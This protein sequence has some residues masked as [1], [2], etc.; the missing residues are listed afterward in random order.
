M[1]T[2][3]EDIS[4]T[5]EICLRNASEFQALRLNVIRSK[6]F[7]DLTRVIFNQETSIELTVLKILANLIILADCQFAQLVLVNKDTSLDFDRV[8]D[9]HADDQVGG[10]FDHLSSP[11]ENRFIVNSGIISI[12]AT[13]GEKV[14]IEDVSEASKENSFLCIPPRDNDNNTIAVVALANKK[15]GR[16]TTDDENFV[17]AFGLLCA[18]SLE[19][20]RNLL[21]PSA[22]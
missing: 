21:K 15:T 11:F 1:S 20:V 2:N 12:V 19:N 6:V 14:N 9:L 8:F 18:I 17:D 7:L 3:L 10:E 22:K 13:V 4:K 5:P 16:F